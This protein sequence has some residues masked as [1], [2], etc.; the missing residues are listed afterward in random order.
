MERTDLRFLGRQ[1]TKEDLTMMQEVVGSC[2]GLTRMELARTV[3]ELLGWKRRNRSLKARECREF[4]E[5]L[6]ARALWALPE[7]R[8]GRPVGSR[9]QVPVTEDGNAGAEIQ[10]TAS[11][12]GRLELELVCSNEGRRLFRELVGRYH[13]LGHAVPFGAHLRYLIYAERPERNVLACVQFSS[14]AWRIR[15]RDEWIG[16]DDDRRGRHLQH[17]VNN[18]RFLVLPW[19]EVKNLASR[20][21]SEAVKRMVVDWKRQYRVEPLLAETLVDPRQYRGTCYRAAN[22]IELGLTRG[23]GRQDRRRSGEEVAPKT[24]LVY[25]LAQNAIERLREN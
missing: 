3:C 20:I 11:D 1:V 8:A 24:V 15:V 6:E 25:P 14:A 23:M 4:L 19:V 7:K 12:V 18:S 16:G 13:Y 9:T 22:W 17:I 10:G 5:K 21:L 2:G